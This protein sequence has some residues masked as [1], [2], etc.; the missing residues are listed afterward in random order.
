[1]PISKRSAE[2]RDPPPTTTRRTEM[3]LVNG[4][5]RTPSPPHPWRIEEERRR[6]HTVGKK[7]GIKH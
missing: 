2:P 1:M 5:T 4:A 6:A 7:V 3:R